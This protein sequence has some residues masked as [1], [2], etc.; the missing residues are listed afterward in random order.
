M[1][2]F[3][4]GI[5]VQKLAIPAMVTWYPPAVQNLSGMNLAAFSWANYF[6]P[7]IIFGRTVFPEGLFPL[8]L[9]M[10]GLLLTLLLPL[11]TFRGD[12]KAVSTIYLSGENVDEA[13]SGKFVSAM[14]GSSQMSLG[15]YYFKNFLNDRTT[16]WLNI[17]ALVLLGI[18]IGV[19]LI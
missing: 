7:A 3:G 6:N 9:L 11:L 12:D 1:L 16:L 17:G 15:G 4:L 13:T 10:A 8:G 14:E 18:S 19:I 2:A 5:V